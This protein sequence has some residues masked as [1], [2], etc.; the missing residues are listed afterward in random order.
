MMF[1]RSDCPPRDISLLTD[2]G[3]VVDIVFLHG[4][5]P[6]ARTTASALQSV[7]LASGGAFVQNGGVTGCVFRNWDR[8]DVVLI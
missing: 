3:L 8:S 4:T 6:H 7:A 5:S 1:G 2:S